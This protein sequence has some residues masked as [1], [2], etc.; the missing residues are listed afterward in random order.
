MKSRVTVGF[1]TLYT[2]SHTAL[3]A[4]PATKFPPGR[5]NIINAVNRFQKDRIGKSD[6]GYPK[7]TDHVGP[8]AV[9]GLFKGSSA[10]WT[11][12]ALH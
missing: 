8:S 7:A 3:L 4:D 12:A 9:V 10:V 2:C 11:E 6:F 5:W 1:M